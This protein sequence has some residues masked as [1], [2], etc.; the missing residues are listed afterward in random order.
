M[1]GSR[2]EVRGA[3]SRARLAAGE[4]D[5]CGGARRHRDRLRRR[6]GPGRSRLPRPL[7]HPDCLHGRE[8]DR[9]LC[10]RP[11]NGRDCRL[12]GGLGRLRRRDRVPDGPDEAAPERLRERSLAARAPVRGGRSPVAVLEVSRMGDAGASR[13]AGGTGCVA[14]GLLDLRGCIRR[15][16]L[17][18]LG[19]LSVGPTHLDRG[20]ACALSPLAASKRIRRRR[21]AP[22]HLRGRGP[23]GLRRGALRG[24]QPLFARALRH[25][26]ADGAT[27][28]LAVKRAL[29][30]PGPDRI[31]VD[32]HPEP[33]PFALD[34]RSSGGGRVA[35]DPALLRPRRAPVVRPGR[36]RHDRYRRRRGAP[37]L[38]RFRSRQ[39]AP[40]RPRP[41]RR[42]RA[43]AAEAGNSAA[44]GGPGVSERVPPSACA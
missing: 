14:L 21:A 19:S 42:R 11:E 41:A 43:T 12:P 39:G 24:D 9:R 2:P 4:L 17:R 27:L 23:R 31:P 13:G 38:P 28:A 1:G 37:P 33:A 22:P 29:D 35:C 30:R 5:R 20:A 25:R 6:F 16:L 32:R 10:D 40:R 26:P 18:G 44:E 7:L 3:R 34:D 8:R 15:P 36:G